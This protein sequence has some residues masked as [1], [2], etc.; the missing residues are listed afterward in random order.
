MNLEP[1]L[2]S[3]LSQKEKDKYHVLMDIYG[4]EKN[5][6]DVSICRVAI[7]TQIER[8]DLCT[9]L[10]KERVGRTE[11][12]PVKHVHCVCAV[13]SDSLQLYGPQAARFLSLGFSRQEY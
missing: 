3:E 2:Q 5:G 7:Q 13:A 6:T 12:A 10:G 1:I 9:Q 8:T 4:I 11:R